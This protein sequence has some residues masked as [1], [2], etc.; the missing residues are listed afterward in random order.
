MLIITNRK[1]N[2][3]QS[4]NYSLQYNKNQLIYSNASVNGDTWQNIEKKIILKSK[5][6]IV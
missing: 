3:N 4:L 1:E 5:E 6:N 2:K